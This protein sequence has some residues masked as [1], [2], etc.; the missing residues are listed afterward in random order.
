MI[1]TS[2]HGDDLY[3]PGVTLGHGLTFNGGLYAFHVP[4]LIH[5]P[6]IEA[7]DQPQTVRTIDIA[8]TLAELAGVELPDNWEGR[9]LAPWLEDET[10]AHDLPVYLETGF[11]FIQFSVEG[12]E[13]PKLPPM[14]EVTVI[15]EDYNYQFVVKPE[16]RQ[17][18]IDAKQRCLVTRNWKLVCTPT[19]DGGR[20]FDLYHI[21]VD[22]DAQLEVSAQ[23]PQVAKV[24]TKALERWMDQRMETPVA[25]IFPGGEP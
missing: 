5:A 25:D 19:A 1:I 21:A 15:D 3:E 22:P 9:S 14:D 18:I 16:F 2:D 7:G 6:G 17:R 4:L 8:P 20:H 23:H 11:P 12:V 10:Q 13:R 24:M